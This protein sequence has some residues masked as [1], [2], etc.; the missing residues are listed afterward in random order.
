MRALRVDVGEQVKVPSRTTQ[1]MSSKI[2]LLKA[3]TLDVPPP[4]NLSTHIYRLTQPIHPI[5][6]WT[7]LPRRL[8]ET[9][10]YQEMERNENISVRNAG[11]TLRDYTISRAIF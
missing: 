7:S 10:L 2:N 4:P 1:C 8:V 5:P 9:S 3:Y 6:N 11:N